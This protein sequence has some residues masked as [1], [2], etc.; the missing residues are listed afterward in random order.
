MK[1][2][3][4]DVA[5]SLAPP[6]L[7]KW[8]RG[9]YLWQGDYASWGEARAAS[10]GYDSGVILERVADAARRVR[11]GEFACER[12]S[13]LFTTLQPSWPLL[14]ALLR[15][16]A[17]RPGGPLHIL[18][19]GGALGSAWYTHR[20]WLGH[21]GDVRWSIVEQPHFVELGRREF[22]VGPVRFFSGMAEARAAR[23][24]L[25]VLLL[26][27]VLQYVEEPEAVL[28]EALRDGVRW[29]VIDRT[30]FVEGNR[31]RLVVQR[32][33]PSIYRASYPARLWS[34][35]RFCS[36]VQAR[37]L[38]IDGEWECIDDG[39]AGGVQ[40]RGYLLR[41]GDVS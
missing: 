15:V 13:V 17:Q 27:S 21:L 35:A 40:L 18:D 22:E 28:D 19:F 14:A 23:G 3:F 31:D 38:R 26:G 30:P 16:A 29:I 11:D 8:V 9:W 4:M 34:R 33:P 20:S 25:D 12:D 32:V 7:V 5:L 10:G 2:R 36:L 24:P 41:A 37:G 1:R 39:N 6:A